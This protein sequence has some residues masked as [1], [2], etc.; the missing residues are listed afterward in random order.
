MMKILRRE[1]GFTVVESAIATGL[2]LVV[3]V[4]ILS[5]LA[6]AQRSQAV[7][8][9]L[10]QAVA[11][12]RAGLDSVAKEVVFAYDLQ[13]VSATAARA[14][15]DANHN[16]CEAGEWVTYRLVASGGDLVFERVP[17]SGSTTRLADHL[18]AASSAI[19]V[20]SLVAGKMLRVVLAVDVNSSSTEPGPTIV[21]TGVLARNAYA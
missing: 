17:A 18:V 8:D 13:T 10:T 9:G 20:T 1:G 6:S 12:A 11:I 16:G 19:S 5:V 4:P 15:F 7:G 21:E 14:C 3:S 2:L